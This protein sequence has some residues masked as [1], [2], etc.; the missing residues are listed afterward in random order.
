[1]NFFTSLF[2][3]LAVLFGSV[4][5]ALSGGAQPAAP[6]KAPAVAVRA[7]GPTELPARSAEVGAD[8]ADMSYAHYDPAAFYAQVDAL[9]DLAAAEDSEGVCALYDRL[10]QEFVYIDTQN[11]LAYIHHSADVTDPYWSE[12]SLYCETLW[13]EAGDALSCACRDIL[14]GPLGESFAAHIGP[15]AAEELADYEAMT[16]RETE[17][18]VREAELINEYYDLMATAADEAVYVYQ[19]E[20][21]SFEKLNGFSGDS[22][23]YEDYEGYWEVSNG[24]EAQ[25]NE[26][27]GPIF[28][29]LV[30]IRGEIAEIRGYES[31]ADYAYES[32][33][34]DYSA[35][36]AQ[37]LCDAVKTI[38]ADYYRRLYYSDLW[39]AYGD[40]A[41][42]L[43]ESALLAALG[44]RIGLFGDAFAEAFRYMTEHSLYAISAAPAALQG[45]YT[46]ELTYYR[47]PYLYMSL[48]G[49]CH[50]FSTLTHEFG[51]FA[52]NYY[53]PIPNVL[54]TAGSYDLFEIHSTGMEALFTE[55]Y[56]G[57]YTE[58]A[59]TAVFIT[60]GG[61]V[62][63]VLEG[64]IY[65]EFQRRIYASPDM[66]LEDINRLYARIL[67][68]Y[69]MSTDQDVSY[70]WMYVS[71]NYE[72]PLYYISYAV[73]ALASLQLWAMAQEDFSAAV[74]AYE[75]IVAQGAY[76]DGYLTVLQ[77]AGL[78]PFTE[79]GA[80]AEILAPAIRQLQNLEMRASLSSAGASAA[81]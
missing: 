31:Y 21:W 43:D 28:V 35:Q 70:S 6:S 53:N 76:D 7:A 24:L 56:D 3:A 65:D 12:E 4:S 5:S 46:T 27:V 71:H 2:L 55:L 74:T 41:P 20:P 59:D 64:C 32:Y 61:L 14:A 60:L 45:G 44:D 77:S 78:R 29:E 80:A 54:T 68:E 8:W 11:T 33:G 26:L 49:D 69:G 81:A 42:V 22:L 47:S 62:E 51:H 72:A 52:E 63:V 25:I 37:A 73:S 48:A 58:N 40:M 18:T 57:I 30:A 34:R 10:Y 9:Y 17:L 36:E 50:D 79:P 38:S 23:Y 67:M 75:A 15:E 66:S 16:G 13:A 19:G 1:M 39:Y